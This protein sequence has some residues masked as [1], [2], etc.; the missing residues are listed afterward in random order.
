MAKVYQFRNF[1]HMTSDWVFAP[2]KSI[3]SRVE[4]VGGEIVE[5]TEQEVPDELLDSEGRY[6]PDRVLR[7]ISTLS[8]PELL[9]AFQRT[10]GEAGNPE[11]DALIGEIERRGLDL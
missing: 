2:F 5:G 8:D 7:H 11:A 6:D 9:A 1:D 10:D 4:A 3:R